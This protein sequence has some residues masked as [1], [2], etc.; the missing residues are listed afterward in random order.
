M[1]R[2][3]QPLVFVIFILGLTTNAEL[4]CS[5][6]TTPYDWPGFLLIGLA[7][8][9]A[10]GLWGKK[11]WGTERPS[12]MCVG[13]FVVFGLWIAARGFVSPISYFARG[14]LA[15]LGVF[16]VVYA[17]C[18]TTFA[19]PSWRKWLIGLQLLIAVGNLGL[20]LYQAIGDPAYHPLPWLERENLR[21]GGLFEDPNHFAA[22]LLFPAC[23]LGGILIGGRQ[24]ASLRTLAALGLGLCLGGF[25]L[26]VSRSG[27]LAASVG[28]FG[29]AVFAFWP[30]RVPARNRWT[31]PLGVAAV[32]LVLV[33]AGLWVFQSE[34]GSNFAQM[35]KSHALPKLG[36]WEPAWK[37]LVA[38]PIVGSGARTYEVFNRQHRPESLDAAVGEHAFAENDVLQLTSEY[39]WVGISLA[40]ICIGVHLSNGVQSVIRDLEKRRKS[41]GELAGTSLALTMGAICALL[42]MLFLALLEAHLHVPSIA[43]MAAM[44]LAILANP[45]GQIRD[46]NEPERHP[47]AAGIAQSAAFIA[48]LLLLW[49]GHRYFQ[50]D[51][52]ELRS[53]QFA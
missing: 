26:A 16:T 31:A 27:F 53:D 43:V 39:G 42:S 13:T 40:L 29:L 7:G 38:E 11:I 34:R 2:F 5:P 46:P 20:A 3:V 44:S 30:R 33:L 1:T 37:Q 28:I 4:A 23:I 19:S 32:A 14:D 25:V 15:L 9:L 50:S 6:E 48:G 51:W 21:A 17:L 8:A 45:T 35:V 36:L 12:L 18:A 47:A 10:I 22:S 41:G 24:K 52:R 49:N